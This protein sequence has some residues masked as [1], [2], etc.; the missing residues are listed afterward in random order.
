MQV[1]FPGGSV[2]KN[3]PANAGDAFDPWVGKIPWSRKWPTPV[4][5]PRKFHGQRSLVGDSPWGRKGSDTS[6]RLS[7]LGQMGFPGGSMVE[8]A[9]QSR[10]YRR[11]QVWSPSRETPIEEEMATHSSILA[12]K[13]LWT[14]EPGRQ[15][16]RHDL[17]TKHVLG[18]ILF[19]EGWRNWGILLF[20]CILSGYNIHRLKF[21][22]HWLLFTM[23][24]F[25]TE[26][27]IWSHFLGD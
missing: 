3:P 5:L 27:S 20:F 14:E 10:S 17:V 7:T 9:C 16:V 1:A 19:G 21:L 22:P 25:L 15:R 11:P 24:Y 23:H 6:A 4:F 2:V 12:W 26:N 8:S 13:I 18:Q